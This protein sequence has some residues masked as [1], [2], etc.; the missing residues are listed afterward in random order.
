[1]IPE[2]HVILF[3][4][5]I[6]VTELIA[7]IPGGNLDYSDPECDATNL[8]ELPRG[9]VF[10]WPKLLVSPD[11][12]PDFQ[13]NLQASLQGNDIEMSDGFKDEVIKRAR[14]NNNKA[15]QR[16]VDRYAKN[17]VIE[18]FAIG[19][20]VVLKLPRGTQISTDMKRVFGKVLAILHEYKYEI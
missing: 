14:A 8:S 5:A 19:D 9:Q 6:T 18:Q 16:M 1:M 2:A 12:L 11:L 4:Q 10:H 7:P 17:H 20:I 3:F 15:R 13:A